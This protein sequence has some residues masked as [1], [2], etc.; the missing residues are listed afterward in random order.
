[1]YVSP[2]GRFWPR[3]WTKADNVTHRAIS[4]QYLTEGPRGSKPCL[5]GSISGVCL[6]LMVYSIIWRG[7][8]LDSVAL[9]LELRGPGCRSGDV[10]LVHIPVNLGTPFLPPHPNLLGI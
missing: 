8:R 5:I 7:Y 3:W 4:R 9:P 10:C 1:M 2:L 6:P